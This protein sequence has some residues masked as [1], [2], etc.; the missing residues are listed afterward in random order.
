MSFLNA[1]HNG[2]GA[3]INP[4][5]NSAYIDGPRK[6]GTTTV[7][8]VIDGVTSEYTEENAIMETTGSKYRASYDSKIY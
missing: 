3:T 6:S 4:S 7:T 1:Y 2:S 8:E 5:A